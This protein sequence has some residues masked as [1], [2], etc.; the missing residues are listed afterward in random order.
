MS[1]PIISTHPFYFSKFHLVNLL[2]VNRVQNPFAA[3]QCVCWRWMKIPAINKPTRRALQRAKKKW[4][5]QRKGRLIPPR[6]CVFYVFGVQTVHMGKIMLREICLGACELDPGA[7]CAVRI[8]IQLGAL[9]KH[10][11]QVRDITVVTAITALSAC[12][13][14]LWRHAQWENFGAQSNKKFFA[15]SQT[16]TSKFFSHTAGWNCCV[17][18]CALHIGCCGSKFINAIKDQKLIYGRMFAASYPLLFELITPRV[19]VQ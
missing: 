9:H 15:L 13:I 6:V 5:S 2:L 11:S 12:C 8:C 4:P 16:H 10:T 14:A 18:L 1:S 7:V 19:Y 3:I 17:R